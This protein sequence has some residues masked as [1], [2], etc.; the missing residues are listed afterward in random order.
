MRPL[1]HKLQND[2]IFQH[3]ITFHINQQKR[4][5]SKKFH[6]FLSPWRMTETLGSYH[7]FKNCVS[8][9]FKYVSQ[10]TTSS[11]IDCSTLIHLYIIK[12]SNQPKRHLIIVNL[13]ITINIVILFQ[14]VTHQSMVTSLAFKPSKQL[15][16]GNPAGRPTGQHKL[17]SPEYLVSDLLKPSR[18]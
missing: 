12:I 3:H 2:T 10:S 9:L 17:T 14:C 11:N 6:M 7:T 13:I 5:V 8:L 1:V 18:Q 15:A 16:L 4:Y